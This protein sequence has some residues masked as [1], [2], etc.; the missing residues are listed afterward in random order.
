MRK[1][2]S[3]SQKHIYICTVILCMLF[4]FS[5]YGQ[6][7]DSSLNNLILPKNYKPSKLGTL[8]NVKKVGT[9]KKDL[10]LVAGWGFDGS[11]FNYF[12]KKNTKKF[13]MHIVTL[14]GFGNQNSPPI[15][16]KGTSYGKQIWTQGNAD[17]IADYIKRKKLEKP[18]IIGHFISGGHT[19]F[20]VAIKYPEL[21]DRLIIISGSAKVGST[22]YPKEP[23]LAERILINDTYY[24]PKWFKTVTKKTWDE[25]NYPPELY[26]QSTT[27]AKEL[28]NVSAS[29]SLPIMIH[30][31]LEYYASDISL[32]FKDL[33]VPTLIIKP[34]FT[35]ALIK[36]YNYL[37]PSYIDSWKNISKNGLIKSVTIPDSNFF[38]MIDQPERFNNTVL[39]FFFDEK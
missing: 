33:K 12:V 26:A 3:I 16:A 9:G 25:Q 23:T 32:E 18:S 37:K 10:I 36:N 22:D 13:T 30:Y 28:W 1:V 6:A 7:Q 27:K 20:R 11:V 15:P 38:I 17:A 14:P 2:F 39:K 4:P 24:A 5:S 8:N 21:I 35:D 34:S 29:I 19:A 31:V